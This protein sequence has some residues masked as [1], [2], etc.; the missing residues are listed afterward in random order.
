MAVSSR[1]KVHLSAKFMSSTHCLLSKL[2]YLSQIPFNELLERIVVEDGRVEVYAVHMQKI[3]IS[4][5]QNSEGTEV[6]RFSSPS[7]CVRN[8]KFVVYHTSV[9]H[10]SHRQQDTSDAYF[11]V[12]AQKIT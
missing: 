11:Q 5:R 10:A 3:L 1:P 6:Y 7:H 9:S 8:S 4:E 2:C 12:H